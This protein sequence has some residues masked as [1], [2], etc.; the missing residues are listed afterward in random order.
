MLKTNR[1]KTYYRTKITLYLFL[2]SSSR[3]HWIVQLHM[4]LELLL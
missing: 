4:L 1:N 2:S 3:F